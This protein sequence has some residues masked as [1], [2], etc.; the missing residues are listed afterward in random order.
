MARAYSF[1]EARLRSP[2]LRLMNAVGAGMGNVGLLRPRLDVASVLEAAKRRCQLDNLADDGVLEALT[3]YVDSA[4]AEA[5]LNTLGRIAVHNMLVDSLCCRMRVLDWCDQ[6]PQVREQEI[7]QPWVIVGLP[8]T[9]TSILSILLGLDPFNRPLL[10]WEAR[11]PIPPPTLATAREDARISEFS[12]TLA[13]LQKMNPAL[14]TMHPFGSTLAEECT[15]LFTY[16]LRT[17]GMETIAFVPSY[18]HWLD[19]ADM[20]P[21]YS[22]HKL[23][24]QALQHA[25]PTQHWVLKS[26][27]HLWSLA[28]LRAA[29]PDA[30]IIW[31][32]RDPARLV[33]SLASLN[34]AMQ[35][36]F[37]R[38]FDPRRVGNYWADKVETAIGRAM[39]FD[40][41]AGGWCCHVRY[42]DLVDDPKRVLENIYRQFGDSVNSLHRQR[43]DAWLVQRPQ[44]AAGIH[45]YN[46]ADFGWTEESLARRYR[47]YREHYAVQS[48]V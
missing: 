45:T 6:Q 38:Q 39:A 23:T 20:S 37:T 27:N 13:Q 12:A 29:Y 22:M 2:A 11:Q 30:R 46:P 17:I 34:S 33:T 28:A 25:Q 24:L 1:R 14:A 48:G 21:A 31:A 18:G 42:E 10:Q 32:H 26:P 35:I 4:E 40:E 36:Q 8:R 19:S 7:R 16:A 5:G 44:H 43:V 41:E 3:R 15:A 9:G 47:N